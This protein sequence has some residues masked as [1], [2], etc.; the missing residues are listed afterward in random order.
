MVDP[1]D[2]SRVHFSF[3][4]GKFFTLVIYSTRTSLLCWLRVVDYISFII[5]IPLLQGKRLCSISLLE[6]AF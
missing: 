4:L 2:E 6:I 5:N 1:L 3:E